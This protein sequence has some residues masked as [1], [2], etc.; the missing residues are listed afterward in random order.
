MCIR[1]LVYVGISLFIIRR[2]YIYLVVCIVTGI[3][4]HY[5][6]VFPYEQQMKPLVMFWNVT[7]VVRCCM[8]LDDTDGGGPVQLQV[9]RKRTMTRRRVFHVF[10]WRFLRN[11]KK[12][13]EECNTSAACGI[14]HMETALPYLH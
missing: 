10:T 2:A 14:E 4:L 3:T 11:E 1:L 12:M 6:A 9:E 7:C 13:G 8:T 5:C